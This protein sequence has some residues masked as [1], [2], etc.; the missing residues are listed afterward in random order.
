M[1]RNPRISACV[2][3]F[4]SGTDTLIVRNVDAMTVWGGTGS[5]QFRSILRLLFHAASQHSGLALAA[6]FGHSPLPPRGGEVRPSQR[7]PAYLLSKSLISCEH[8]LAIRLA[9]RSRVSA[10]IDAPILLV[11]PEQGALAMP[12]NASVADARQANRIL[13]APGPVWHRWTTTAEFE[14]SMRQAQLRDARARLS[15]RVEG[16]AQGQSAVN[17]RRGKTRAVIVGTNEWS[18]LRGVPSF[19][20]LLAMTLFDRGDMWPRD[21]SPPREVAPEPKHVLC[22]H[23]VGVPIS[24]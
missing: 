7:S 6:N 4:P 10:T 24:L 16:A 11:G 19:G 13:P 9:H 2:P 1:C 20:L 12:M 5:Q 3:A 8:L 22:A 17:T 18:R 14:D 15:A 21:T 23:A